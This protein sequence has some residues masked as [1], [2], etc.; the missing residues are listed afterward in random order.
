M[1]LKEASVISG[2]TPEE[3]ALRLSILNRIESNF[4]DSHYYSESSRILL[5]NGQV[6]GIEF[7]KRALEINPDDLDALKYLV[8]AGKQTANGYLLSEYGK[9]LVALDPFT[10]LLD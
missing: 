6:E 9:R 2:S 5:A 8:I 10:D 1:A 7:A 4:I 3:K